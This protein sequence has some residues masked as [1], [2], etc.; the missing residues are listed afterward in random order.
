MENLRL[1]SV[2]LLPSTLKAIDAFVDAH[3]PMKRN[4]VINQL[5]TQL[6]ECCDDAELWR[7]MST[8]AA[9]EKGMVIRCEISRDAMEKRAHAVSHEH[10]DDEDVI[11]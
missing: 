6:M 10:Y 3:Q 4:A 5:L 7:M 9:Y 1:I 2:R 8:Y 11:F